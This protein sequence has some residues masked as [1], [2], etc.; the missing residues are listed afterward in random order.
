MFTTTNRNTRFAICAM[1]IA[2]GLEMETRST[3]VRIHQYYRWK[4]DC[5]QTGRS[6]TAP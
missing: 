6:Q 4:D 5:F 2:F 1:F 3:L